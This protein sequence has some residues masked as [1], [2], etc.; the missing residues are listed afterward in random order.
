MSL[1]I[2]GS[3]NFDTIET[4]QTRKEMIVGGSCSFAALSAG[5]FSPPGVVAVIGEDFPQEVITLFQERG[6]DTRGIE[7][8]PGK[9]FHWEGRYGVDPNQRETIRTDL[10]VFQD[11]DPELLPDYR[12]AEILFLGNIDPDLQESIHRQAD[13]PRLVAMDT[14]RFWIDTKPEALR[15]V[16]GQVDVFFANDEEVRLIADKL[17]LIRA[18]RRLQELGPSLIVIKKGEHGAL[19]MGRDFMCAVPAW[20]CENVT[21]PTGAGDSFGGGFLG[22]LDKIGSFGE[23]DVRRAAAYGSVMASFTIED[24]GIERLKIL[25]HEEIEARFD[26]FRKLASF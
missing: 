13:G 11:F 22:Y 23:E 19:V 9:T 25:S 12:K 26:D 14:I 6:I 10:N 17:N 5:Y 16:L 8:L 18:G 4:P 24:F 7:R 15:R 20:P 21:D 2:V 1:V 3:L